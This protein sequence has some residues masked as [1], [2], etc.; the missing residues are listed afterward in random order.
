MHAVTL[1]E[2]EMAILW[3]EICSVL[4]DLF[5]YLDSVWILGIHGEVFAPSMAGWDE[6]NVVFPTHW[7]KGAAGTWAVCTT[8]Q[9]KPVGH[10]IT[11]FSLYLQNTETFYESLCHLKEIVHS[12][13][14]SLRTIMSFQ[15][16][17]FFHRTQKGNFLT[18]IMLTL[19]KWMRAW[20]VSKWSNK[21]ST[22]NMLHILYS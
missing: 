19:L 11:Q 22:I 16:C 8:G 10:K 3:H 4:S 9:K 1:L 21:T 2:L 14:L 20:A 12:K 17:K 13:I 18:N 5:I 7:V 15:T 6:L